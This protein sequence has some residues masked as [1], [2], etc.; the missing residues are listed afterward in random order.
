MERVSIETGSE[1][2]AAV[3]WLHG[4]GADG[5]DFEPIIPELN[6]EAVCDVRFIF[7]HAPVR[8]VTIN[9]GMVMRAWYD[10]LEISIERRVDE[11]GIF[12]S[13][14]MIQQLIDEQL[15]LGIAP[16]RLIL[17]GFS[18]GGAMAYH[19]GLRQQ[20]PLGGLLILSAYLPVPD[21]LELLDDRIPRST[22]VLCCHGELDPVVPIALGESSA[23]MVEQAGWPLQFRS[24]PAPHSL[25]P[26]EVEEIGKWLAERLA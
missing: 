26:D 15:Q 3:I 2:T 16:E 24:Y 4:L 13:A 19:V 6:L 10:I 17:A 5:H 22:P 14:E 23:R 20:P 8:P 11:A 1:P 12:E 18:Q 9:N 7:P 25:H 21:A